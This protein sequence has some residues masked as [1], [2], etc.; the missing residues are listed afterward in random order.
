MAEGQE[1]DLLVIG[2]LWGIDYSQ[3]PDP[4]GFF[5]SAVPVA[6]DAGGLRGYGFLEV[7]LL[8]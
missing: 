7:L 1:L 4:L 8:R 2:H 3:L 5:G 6:V